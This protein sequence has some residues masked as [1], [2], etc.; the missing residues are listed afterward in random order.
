[1]VTALIRNY[2][3]AAHWFRKAAEQ[4]HSFAQFELGLLYA[5]GDGV[6]QNYSE[7]AHWFL[8]AAEQEHVDAQYNLATIYYN[9]DGVERDPLMAL[10]WYYLAAQR[11]HEDAA[12]KRDSVFSELS[13]EQ[14]NQAA[15]MLFLLG[16]RYY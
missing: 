3:E 9:G 6:D 2:S 12:S 14:T 15:R 1:M 10:A 5:N 7:A 4:E 13:K 11:G 16:I 8:K